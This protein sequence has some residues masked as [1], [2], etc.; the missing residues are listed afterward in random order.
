MLNQDW[1]LAR[2]RED[3]KRHLN[4]PPHY[5]VKEIFG[6]RHIW[7]RVQ[8]ND[9]WFLPTFENGKLNTLV[10]AL[11]G[12]FNWNLPRIINP[13]QARKIETAYEKLPPKADS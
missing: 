4:E 11:G 7:L 3:T 10:W 1:A 8:G 13:K 9:G 5:T 2:W 12:D 6:A